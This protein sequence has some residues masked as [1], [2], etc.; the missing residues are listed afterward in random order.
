MSFKITFKRSNGNILHRECGAPELG[1]ALVLDP[2]LLCFSFLVAIMMT[3]S[4]YFLAKELCRE[5]WQA[6]SL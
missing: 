1:L 4:V 3:Q 2:T 5:G 6:L